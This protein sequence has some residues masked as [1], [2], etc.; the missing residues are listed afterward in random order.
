MNKLSR[1][2]QDASGVTNQ[3]LAAVCDDVY[4]VVCGI[5]KKIKG[6]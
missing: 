1:E 4:L 3:I 2:F 6:K 5:P